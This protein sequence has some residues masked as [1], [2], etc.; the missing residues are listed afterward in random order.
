[1]IRNETLW[2]LAKERPES[3]PFTH[4]VIDDFFEKEVADA[5]CEEFPDYDSP[6]IYKYE[7]PI[8]IKRAM[9]SWDKFP[10]ATYK[11]FTILCSERFAKLVSHPFNAV[12]YPDYGLH[13]GGCH[14][15]GR[16]GKLNV[17]QD[18]SI[19]PKMPLQR[20]MNIIIYMSRDW[21]PTW[22]GGL[23]LWSHNFETNKP[24]ECVRRVDVKFNRAVLFDTTQNSWHGLPEPINCPENMYRKSLAM[25]YLQEPA[26]AA[27]KHKK[28]W[29]A[30][31]KDQENDQKIIDLIERR[32]GV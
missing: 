28:A 7:N 4:M 25:Y 8:E 32:K 5:I 10:A 24:K 14:M 17:H 27:P 18:Y 22:G 15:H 19:H 1:M 30:P 13:G 9:N 6:G 3:A 11:A 26:I 12:L 21:D 2:T 31:Y 23:E 29:Y 20:K 16:G